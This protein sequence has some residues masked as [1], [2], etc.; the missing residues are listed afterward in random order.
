MRMNALRQELQTALLERNMSVIN[1]TLNQYGET[2]GHERVRTF[3]QAE[4]LAE[5]EQ[6]LLEWFWSNA[7]E[8]EAVS[9]L[10][11]NVSA[12]AVRI[13]SKRNFDFGEDFSFRSTHTGARRLMVSDSAERSLLCALPKERHAGLRLILRTNSFNNHVSEHDSGSNT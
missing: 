11:E 13:L 10:I 7:A 5:L 1:Q 3:F 8:P 2:L 12:G 6:N 9:S 4:L